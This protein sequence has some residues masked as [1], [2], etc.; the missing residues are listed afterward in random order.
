MPR[1]KKDSELISTRINRVKR[2]YLAQAVIDLGYSYRR[3]DPVTGTETIQPLW[4]EWLEAIADKEL[5]MYKK[6][7]PPT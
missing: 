4:G 2:D 3:T 1:P 7:S 5:I 6:V